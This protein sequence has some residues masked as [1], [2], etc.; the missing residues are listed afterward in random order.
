[1]PLTFSELQLDTS[2]ID[3]LNR[4]GIT[5]PTP[6]QET[7]IPL[8]MEGKDV[9][10]QSHT[11]S[12][13]TLAFLTPLFQK[14]DTGKREMQVLILA[15]THEL[16]MQIHNQINLL[17]QNSGMPVTAAS[18]IGGA[19][20]EKQIKKLKEKPHFVVGSAGRILEL[21]KK[22]K[23]TAHTLK[24]I[25]LDEADNLLDNTNTRTIQD[26]IKTTLRDRQLCLFSASISG[27]TMELAQSIM[28]E[29]VVLTNEQGQEMNPNIEHFYL[30]GD[31]RDK[32]DLLRRL[33]A[34][35]EPERALIFV[36][37]NESMQEIAEK[38][39]FHK[40]ELF[41][42]R[43]NIKKEERK[44]ALEAFRQGKV[45]LLVSSDLTARGLDVPEISH[46]I[47][48]DC[49]AS[50]DEYLHRSGR[51][52]RVNGSGKSITIVTPKDLST[53]KKYQKKFSIEIKEAKLSHGQLV[54]S[55]TE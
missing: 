26:I 21:I 16:V 28:K 34:A 1:M 3:G 44:Q 29:P 31:R 32:F 45:K 10:A 12:G 37:Q 8:I 9:I 5:I 55:Q 27:N 17:A 35:E 52:A 38:L 7:A 42:M 2:L 43:G 4:Q 46:V 11:G 36:N 20:V 33:I 53:L 40:K 15:P 23:L 54:S 49:P 25:V 48:L 24:T 51:T 47:Q 19:N 18:I 30:Q 14:V 41:V 6:I 22:R 13:K 39:Q 50:P